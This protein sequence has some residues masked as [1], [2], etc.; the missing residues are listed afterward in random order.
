MAFLYFVSSNGYGKFGHSKAYNCRMIA[1]ASTNPLYSHVSIRYNTNLFSKL[2]DNQ[3]NNS[4]LRCNSLVK[5][6]V[7]DC[8]K[9]DWFAVNEMTSQRIISFMKKVNVIEDMVDYNFFTHGILYFIE[10]S[11]DVNKCINDSKII[12]LTKFMSD[13]Y[14][15]GGMV[16]LQTVRR[17]PSWKHEYLQDVE[18]SFVNICKSCGS[19]ALKGCCSEYSTTNRKKLKM[20]MGWHKS[21]RVT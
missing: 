1:Y 17:H 14:N 20:V 13:N 8:D 16:L 2:M 4:V 5:F 18:T 11:Y 6:K 12:G 19:K 10:N 21:L 3:I 9:S 15:T 7:H